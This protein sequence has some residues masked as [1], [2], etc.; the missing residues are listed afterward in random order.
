M[1]KPYVLDLFSG[2]G[3]ASEA[4]VQA[5][6]KVVRIE[7][8]ILLEYV[9]FTVMKDIL[10]WRDWIDQLPQVEWDLVWASPPCLDFSNAYHAPGPTAAREGREFKPNMSLVVAAKEI[11]EYLKPKAWVIENVSGSVPHF[12]PLLGNYTQK[13][14]AFHLWGRFP[15][16][17]PKA[18]FFHSKS[19]GETWSDDP[20]RSNRRA[21]IPFEISY[22]LMT[23]MRDQLTL[24]DFT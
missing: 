5:G 19:H 12:K 20:M 1:P 18:G 13:I 2:L 3:G 23:A 15:L 17:I 7:N 22:A 6:C 10:E 16:I 8:N 9:P 24:G 21:M 4:F 11:I 14:S